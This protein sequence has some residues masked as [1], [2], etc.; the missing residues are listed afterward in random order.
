MKRQSNGVWW[1]I[2]ANPAV[3]GREPASVPCTGVVGP[4]DGGK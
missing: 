4:K 2:N 1:N 3:R